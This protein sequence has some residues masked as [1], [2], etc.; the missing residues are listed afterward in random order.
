MLYTYIAALSERKNNKLKGEIIAE[1]TVYLDPIQH[2][3]EVFQVPCSP[4]RCCGMVPLD[5][6]LYTFSDCLRIM[7][8]AP[9]YFHVTED[10]S[11]GRHGSLFE[12]GHAM[13]RTE[14]RDESLYCC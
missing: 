12:F 4:R 14:L 1:R 13:G 10:L 9:G 11:E 5:Q 7:K 2:D 3:A 8:Q 6:V